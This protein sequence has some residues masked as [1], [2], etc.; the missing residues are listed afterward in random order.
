MHILCLDYR[1]SHVFSTCGF[2]HKRDEE[3]MHTE[4]ISR[5]GN[6][7]LCSCMSGSAV[8]GKT[9]YQWLFVTCGSQFFVTLHHGRTGIQT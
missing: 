5:D 7:R 9:I 8:N 6:R 2:G 4:I 3:A 1:Y